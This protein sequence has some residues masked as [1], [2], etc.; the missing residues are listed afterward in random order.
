MNKKRFLTGT[1][2][3]SAASALAIDAELDNEVS[4]EEAFDELPDDEVV[5]EV[6]NRAGSPEETVTN[7]LTRLGELAA[8]T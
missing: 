6:I 1:A 7:L 8:E 4:G 2:L 3:F 5:V